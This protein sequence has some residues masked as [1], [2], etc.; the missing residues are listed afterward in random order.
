M[1]IESGLLFPIVAVG[2]HNKSDEADFFLF[3]KRGEAEKEG[4]WTMRGGLGER[5]SVVFSFAVVV[6]DTELVTSMSN[7]LL[8]ERQRDNHIRKT[9]F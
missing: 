5:F 1:W 7:N 9:T 6:T 4:F 3:T 8:I 2:R